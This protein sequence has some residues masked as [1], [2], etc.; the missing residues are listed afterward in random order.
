MRLV[1]DPGQDSEASVVPVV[2]QGVSEML[3]AG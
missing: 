1:S 3:L 2:G